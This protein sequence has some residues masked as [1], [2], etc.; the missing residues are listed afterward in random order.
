[1]SRTAQRAAAAGVV[2][3][4]EAIVQRVGAAQLGEGETGNSGLL[5]DQAGRQLGRN[6]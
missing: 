6:V 1:M 5:A 2:L 3:P 4:T